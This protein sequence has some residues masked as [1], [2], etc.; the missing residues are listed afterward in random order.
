MEWWGEKA[1]I[2][3]EKIIYKKQFTYLLLFEI[4][5]LFLFQLEMK[6]VKLEKK[7]LIQPHNGL[8]PQLTQSSYSTAA[9][10]LSIPPMANIR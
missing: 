7:M 6:M 4:L 3:N 8:P 1:Y 5:I 10:V 9:A 2:V